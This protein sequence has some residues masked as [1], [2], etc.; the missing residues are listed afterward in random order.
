MA[1]VAER[2][3][4]SRT[5]VSFILDGKPGASDETKQRV[6]AIAEEIGYRPD[7]AARL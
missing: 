5:L 1:D 2:A 4:V 7:S 6:L 3:G